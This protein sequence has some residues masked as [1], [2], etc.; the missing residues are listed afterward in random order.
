M[1]ASTYSLSQT[2]FSTEFSWIK[3]FEFRLNFKKVF[4]EGSNSQFVSIDLDNGLVRPDDQ[5]ISES[6]MALFID[7]YMRHQKP[8]D[9]NAGKNI[10]DSL[11]HLNHSYT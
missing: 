8:V 11:D 2:T 1:V 10:F 4:S 7:A 9:R 6:M 5:P 3:L